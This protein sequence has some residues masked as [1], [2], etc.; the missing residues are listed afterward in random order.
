[1]G[2]YKRN[3]SDEYIKRRQQLM[4]GFT[5]TPE[6]RE[7]ISKSKRLFEPEEVIECYRR[8]GYNQVAATRKLGMKPG[9]VAR[10][11]Q[12]L[13]ARNPDLR[14]QLEQERKHVRSRS[15]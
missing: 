2:L 12:R 7:R 4:E 1:M 8:N 9:Y 5:H 10:Y 11:L 13:Y 14:T 15:C 6:A 3:Y